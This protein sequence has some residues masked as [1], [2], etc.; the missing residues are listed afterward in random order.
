VAPGF[1]DFGNDIVG[2]P[3]F[4]L[5]ASA[6]DAGIVDDDARTFRC[7]QFRNLTSDTP[8]GARNDCRFSFEV[9]MKS[10]AV[11]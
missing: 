4:S 10:S 2:R 3:F 7:E 9:H 6:A 11:D 8:A 5:F 1:A